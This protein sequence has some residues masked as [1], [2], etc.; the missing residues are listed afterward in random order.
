MLPAPSHAATK[1]ARHRAPRGRR[2][3]IRRRCARSREPLAVASRAPSRRRPRHRLASNSHRRT[4]TPSGARAS[5]IASPASTRSPRI[6][7]CGTS[8]RRRSPER[9]ETPR[10]DRPRARLVARVRRLV[11]HEHARRRDALARAR[12]GAPCS[13]PRARRRR[14]RRRRRSSRSS[15]APAR[16]RAELRAEIIERARRAPRARSAGAATDRSPPRSAKTG[17]RPSLR[18]D[19]AL[20]EDD[21]ARDD[22]QP[23]H[24]H[25]LADARRDGLPRHSAVCLAPPSDERVVDLAG[26]TFLVAR[27]CRTRSWTYSTSCST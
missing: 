14:W 17:A 11:E 10:A 4:T 3:A 7:A 21:V 5:P 12:G 23:A 18:L 16:A 27:R 6:V 24:D 26:S 19:D 8:S 13:S 25:P 15:R 9:L 22:D 1:R 2:V 20:E